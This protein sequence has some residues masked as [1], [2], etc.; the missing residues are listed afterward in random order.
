MNNHDLRFYFEYILRTFLNQ[1]LR[2]ISGKKNFCFT[3][4]E[5]RQD[6]NS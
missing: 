4:P 6:A 2:T 3:M 5:V 1:C